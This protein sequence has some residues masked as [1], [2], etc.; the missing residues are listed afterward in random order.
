MRAGRPCRGHG[1][2]QPWWPAWRA[3]QQHQ[4]EPAAD[5][6]A[7]VG[8]GRNCEAAGK[9]R[10]DTDAHE[11]KPQLTSLLKLPLLALHLVF[12]L[13]SS[14]IHLEFI[15]PC[16][17]SSH[18]SSMQR[19]IYFSALA[20]LRCVSETW[21]WEYKLE[22][23]TGMDTV[24][25]PIPEHGDVHTIIHINQPSCYQLQHAPVFVQYYR[26]SAM[27]GT[28]HGTQPCPLILYSWQFYGADE[29]CSPQSAHKDCAIQQDQ[30]L[31]NLGLPHSHYY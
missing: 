10:N 19:T 16:G 31:L 29:S 12:V 18:P 20:L 24:G 3:W 22:R 17:C 21:I 13:Y 14:R 23:K 4:P 27:S 25:Q 2:G 1:H 9:A 26:L 5:W 15:L 28:T 30:P 8:Q 7:P 11:P 6:A